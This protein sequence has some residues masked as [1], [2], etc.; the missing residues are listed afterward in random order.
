MNT[1]KATN[2]TTPFRR[3]ALAWALSSTL[4]SVEPAGDSAEPKLGKAATKKTLYSDFM[5][6]GLAARETDAA[7]RPTGSPTLFNDRPPTTTEL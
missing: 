4:A 7:K 5:Q 1:S 6:T 2:K 3:W